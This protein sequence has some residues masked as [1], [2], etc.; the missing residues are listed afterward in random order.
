MFALALEHNKCILHYDIIL[1]KGSWLIHLI[2]EK[3]MWCSNQMQAWHSLLLISNH[4]TYA[5]LCLLT[6]EYH[7]NI[8]FLQFSAKS[9]HINLM[10]FFPD[11]KMSFLFTGLSGFDWVMTDNTQLMPLK[12]ITPFIFP[13]K[14]WE[15]I[16][17]SCGMVLECFALIF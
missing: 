12:V 8:F 15:C 7:V 1:S 13:S 10:A 17:F 9:I 2:Q 6:N 3:M 5:I 16:C 14:A 4:Y 11:W